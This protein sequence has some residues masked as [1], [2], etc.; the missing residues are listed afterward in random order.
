MEER[1]ERK[2]LKNLRIVENENKNIQTKQI[3]IRK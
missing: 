2:D 1:Y 3:G